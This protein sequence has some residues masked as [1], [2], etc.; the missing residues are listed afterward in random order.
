MQTN[1]FPNLV[2]VEQEEHFYALRKATG[3]GAMN[4]V[5]KETAS[6]T[7]PCLTFGTSIS[8]FTIYYTT[9]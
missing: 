8:A 1:A 9:R 6:W 2:V 7:R 5:V 4:K 3:G